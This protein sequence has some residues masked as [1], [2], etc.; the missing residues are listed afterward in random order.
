MKSN[1]YFLFILFV[2]SSCSEPIEKAT[3]SKLLVSSQEEVINPQSS[4][5]QN[6]PTEGVTHDNE[7]F[8]VIHTLV[9]LCDNIHQGIVPVSESLGNGQDPKSNLY[10][11]AAY[12]IKTYFQ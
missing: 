10:W 7:G 3:D 6:N 9:G 4:E 8:K 2:F 1:L 11:G 12:G 5:I